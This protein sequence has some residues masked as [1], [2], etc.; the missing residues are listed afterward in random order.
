MPV[1]AKTDCEAEEDEED[2][3]DIAAPPLVIRHADVL[4]LEI[5]AYIDLSSSKLTQRFAP[6][7]GSLE[8][9]V[10]DAA[11][12]P[13]KNMKTKWVEENAE[14]DAEAW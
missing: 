4:N 12:K 9:V 10:V 5:K 13:V 1:G 3:S 6:D 8:P 2:E 14:W 11:K 7:Q